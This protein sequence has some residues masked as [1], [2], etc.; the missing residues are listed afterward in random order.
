VR[1][2]RFMDWMATNNATLARPADRPRPGDFTWARAGVP[3]EVMVSLA[4]RLGADP[5]FTLPHAAEDALVREIAEVVR[6]GLALGLTTHVEY[7]N[8]VWNWQFDQARW[9]DDRGR[10]RWGEATSWVQ[11]YALRAM[12]VAGIWAEVFGDRPLVRV[13][14]SQTGWLGLEGQIL[15]APLVVAEGLPPPRTA[16]D[17]YAVTGYFAAA[18]GTPDRLPLVR[19]WLA[20]SL[21]DA[22]AR[23]AAQGLTGPARA[24]FVA[25]HRHDLAIARAAAELADGSVTGQAED[26]LAHLLGVV[27]PHHAQA[28]RAAGLRLMM[29]EGGTHVVAQGAG[30]EDAEVTAFFHALNY[31]PE[32]GALYSRLLAGWAGLTDAPFNAFTD[33]E[34]PT[35]WGS[36]GALRHLGDDNP[37]WRALAAGCPAC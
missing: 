25:A 18:L 8:E 2:V 30:I 26:T 7:S 1:L 29:Y 15:D 9:A 4:N 31:A 17:A 12:Q 6:D 27:L 33:V 21:R 34:A 24:D 3:V 13:I 36:W 16:F 23:A 28:A 35:K 32:M 22:A 37:R 11:F 5:W 14:S 20:E 10:E 19:S